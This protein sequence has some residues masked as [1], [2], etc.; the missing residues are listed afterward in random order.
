VNHCRC[1]AVLAA[2]NTTHPTMEPYP[3][4]LTTCRCGAPLIFEL[5]ERV[6][7][8]AV[9]RPRLLTD[10]EL[11]TLPDYLRFQLQLAVLR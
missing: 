8:A 11:A 5:S 6:L 1:G 4:D 9:L 7:G 3:G 2:Y 10:D